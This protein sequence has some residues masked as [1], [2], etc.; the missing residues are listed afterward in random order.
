M[1]LQKASCRIAV[2]YRGGI[3]R[4]DAC[5]QGGDLAEKFYE[6]DS[7]R[8]RKTAHHLMPQSGSH[9]AGKGQQIP[10]E[11]KAHQ[12]TISFHPWGSWRWQNSSEVHTI[13]SRTSSPSLCQGQN[14]PSSWS[15]WAGGGQ[16]AP[17]LSIGAEVHSRSR[18]HCGTMGM[19]AGSS[20]G[21]TMTR[22]II[23]SNTNNHSSDKG[24]CRGGLL[25]W[26]QMIMAVM[27]MDVDV[28]VDRCIKYKQLWWWWM[29]MWKRIVV[30]NTN[31]HGGDEHWWG[32]GSLYQIQ[33]ILWGCRPRRDDGGGKK[34]GMVCWFFSLSIIV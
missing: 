12:P 3:H 13:T 7:R 28:D 2:K 32:D 18:P 23:V 16:T 30:S 9:C 4:T 29:W 15:R 31:D 33:M 11:D 19:S 24:G 25:Y 5:S 21:I 22:A 34:K 14:S 1:E 8:R 17:K 10:C 27:S 26:I 20:R 6:R